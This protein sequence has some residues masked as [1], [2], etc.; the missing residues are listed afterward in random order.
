M[1]VAHPLHGI[2]IGVKDKFYTG[3]GFPTEMAAAL[4]RHI[5]DE[6]RERWGKLPRSGRRHHARQDGSPPKGGRSW[7]RPRPATHGS[8]VHTPG[9]S[10]SGSA[11]AVA[12]GSWPG[13]SRDPGD[14]KAR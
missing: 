11:A 12:A 2:P 5:T 3:P 14:Q 1:R 4:R 10:S 9:G 8:N 7:F 13:A 6:N